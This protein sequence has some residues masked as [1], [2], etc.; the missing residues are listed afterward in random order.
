M[1]QTDCRPK[2][3]VEKT[4]PTCVKRCP[5]GRKTMGWAYVNARVVITLEGCKRLRLHIRRCPDRACPRYHKP[6][7]PE[8]EGRLAL[9]EHPFGLEVIA[10][11]GASRYPQHRSVPEIHQMLVARGVEP[12]RRPNA[13]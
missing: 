13:A 11:I 2:A 12:P 8:A 5:H 7:R 9:P 4:L 10:L 1:A 3:S 6:Y